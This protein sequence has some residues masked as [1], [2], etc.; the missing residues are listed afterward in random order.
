MSGLA[1]VT[2][3]WVKVSFLQEPVVTAILPGDKSY[4][5]LVKLENTMRLACSL[6]YVVSV[7]RTRYDEHGNKA[8]DCLIC[9]KEES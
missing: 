9:R 2:E 5:E 7:R 6:P 3:Y 8:E 4:S 1:G